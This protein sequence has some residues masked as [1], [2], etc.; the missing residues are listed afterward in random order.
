[1]QKKNLG[2]ETEI[3]Q[4]AHTPS[5]LDTRQYTTIFCFFKL[6]ACIGL[7]GVYTQWA[8]LHD[9]TVVVGSKQLACVVTIETKYSY[10][11]GNDS[12][13]ENYLRTN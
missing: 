3:A 10:N 8:I 13:F 7:V 6:F 12:L 4:W 5:G 2:F 9:Y 1:M 11:D